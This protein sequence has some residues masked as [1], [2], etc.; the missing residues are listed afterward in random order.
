MNHALTQNSPP[1]CI[2]IGIGKGMSRVSIGDDLSADT[3]SL[4]GAISIKIRIIF[5]KI[6]HRKT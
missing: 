2:R 5:L 6:C 3:P 1:F 4:I